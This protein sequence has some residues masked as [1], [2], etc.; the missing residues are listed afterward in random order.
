MGN[1]LKCEMS[2]YKH[3]TQ[4]T[5]EVFLGS[6]YLE[7]SIK[8]IQKSNALFVADYLVLQLQPY[9]RTLLEE[10]SPYLSLGSD[11][12]NTRMESHKNLKNILRI[13]C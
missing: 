2:L 12:A 3:S 7:D 6:G 8:M 1:H 5:T 10:K 11:Q 9:I 4:S 13:N